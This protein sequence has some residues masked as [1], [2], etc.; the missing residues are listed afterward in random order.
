MLFRN[1]RTKRQLAEFQKNADPLVLAEEKA[2]LEREDAEA[3]SASSPVLPTA[4]GAEMLNKSYRGFRPVTA[5]KPNDSSWKQ[6]QDYEP[7][8]FDGQKD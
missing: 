2:A 7:E 5:L 1:F 8:K 3:P 4:I 6:R